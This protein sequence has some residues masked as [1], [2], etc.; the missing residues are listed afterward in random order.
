[1]IFREELTGENSLDIVDSSDTVKNLSS[2]ITS[3][4]VYSCEINCASLISFM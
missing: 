3:L 4:H 2:Y 1:M